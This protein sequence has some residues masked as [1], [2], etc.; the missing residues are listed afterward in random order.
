MALPA[1]EVGFWMSVFFG[2]S[3]L[4]FCMVYTLILFSDL[5]ADIINPIE[6][7][8][9]VNR[10]RWPEYITHLCLFL[11]LLVRGQYLVSLINL[12]VLAHDGNQL[13][14]NQ[15]LLDNTTIFVQLPKEKRI[16]ELKLIFFLVSFFIYLIC[17]LTSILKK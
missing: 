8:E 6:L 3:W 5:M 15:H 13:T 12:P 7:C 17:F 11:M 10:Y 14:N 9:R 16:A 4:L 2:T 1:L